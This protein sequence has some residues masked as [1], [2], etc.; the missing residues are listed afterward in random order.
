MKA[1]WDNVGTAFHNTICQLQSDWYNLLSTIL[2]VVASVCSALNDL[3]FVEFDYSGITSAADNY[4]SKAA[5]A[6]GNKQD[7][8]SISDAWSAGSSKFDTFQSGWSTEAFN[9]GAK[10]GNEKWDKISGLKDV[11]SGADTSALA[12]LADSAN[13]TAGNTGNTAKNSGKIADAVAVSAENLKYIRDIAEQEAINRFTT[14][15]ITVNMTN[16]N[17]I[18]SDADLD[19]IT[20]HLRT[21]I[22]AEMNAVAEGVY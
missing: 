14:A 22:E 20:E 4:A 17:N 16:N 18:N 3:P 13:T 9:A 6:S 5:E 15:E 7:Y 2:D 10:W 1:C 21:E 8:K 11:L 19:G 12:N